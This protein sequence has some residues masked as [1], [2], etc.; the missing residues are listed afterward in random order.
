M[1]RS[2]FQRNPEPAP[3]REEAW[4]PVGVRGV[5][6]EIRHP[7]EQNIILMQQTNALHSKLLHFGLLHKQTRCTTFH[8]TLPLTLTL[9]TQPRTLSAVSILSVT[10]CLLG[11]SG[12][13]CRR[14]EQ[15]ISETPAP[16]FGVFNFHIVL[17]DDSSM[18][19]APPTIYGGEDCSLFLGYPRLSWTSQLRLFLHSDVSCLRVPQ[20][21][22]HIRFKQSSKKLGHA[23]S[24]HSFSWQNLVSQFGSGQ[25]PY[26]NQMAI[27][28]VVCGLLWSKAKTLERS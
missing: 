6:W 23:I 18:G 25:S 21:F 22:Q 17:Q 2:N 3:E 20:G 8:H 13:I 24:W 5:V 7:T 28:T 11:L 26:A 9:S 4:I 1:Q 15:I 14:Q 19:Q 10:V 12:I 27:Y 16:Y